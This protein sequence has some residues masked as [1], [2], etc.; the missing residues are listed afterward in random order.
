M[1]DK[2]LQEVKSPDLDTLKAEYLGLCQQVGEKHL[3]LEL[4]TGELNSLNERLRLVAKDLYEHL[5]KQPAPAQEAE[6]V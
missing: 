5:Q 3:H 6:Q 2:K 4:M 1:E